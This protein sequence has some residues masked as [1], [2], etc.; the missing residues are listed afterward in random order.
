[1]AQYDSVTNH[2]RIAG[3][4]RFALKGEATR[5]EDHR[6]TDKENRCRV[7]ERNFRPS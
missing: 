1:M 6:G 3:G 4:L 5:E 7:S 2:I